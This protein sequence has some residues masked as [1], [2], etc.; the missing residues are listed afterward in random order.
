LLSEAACIYFLVKG[1][2]VVYVGKS[3]ILAIRLSTHCKEKDFDRALFL[4]VPTDDASAIELA[5][6]KL[7]RPEYNSDR[8]KMPVESRIAEY[9]G[10]T[11]RYM[12]AIGGDGAEPTEAES[13]RLLT[14]IERL[15]HDHK[16]DRDTAVKHRDNG[17]SLKRLLRRVLAR[18]ESGI[19]FDGSDKIDWQLARDIRNGLV[20]SYS[21]DD[22][23]MEDSQ[24]SYDAR[25]AEK[26]D[27]PLQALLD[28]LAADKDYAL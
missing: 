3:D 20:Y 2:R 4:R 16:I 17:T 15:D 9:H 8:D 1:D 28:R 13:V 11:S 6:I 19:P 23:W 10:H 7:L 25:T 24:R 5:F 12:R 27:G 14:V 21:S 26:D 18:L 22:E